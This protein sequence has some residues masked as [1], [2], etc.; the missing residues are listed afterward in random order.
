MSQQQIN[1]RIEKLIRE[2]DLGKEGYNAEEM[3]FIRQYEGWGGQ[4]KKGEGLLYEFYTPD[5]VAGLM[6][7]LAYRYG[8]DGGN[9]LEPAIGTGRLIR[10][11][12]DYSR[13]VGFEIN[14]VSAR[15][16]EICYP[17]VQVHKG[18]F[19]TAFMAAPRYTRRM[20]SGLTWLKEYPFSL[21]I[22]NP[23]YGK[24]TNRY[25]PYFGRPAIPQMEIFFMY[26]GVQLLRSE[27]ILI[28][29]TASGFL[30][31][32]HSYDAIKK[33]LGKFCDLE[34]AYRLPPVFK[35]SKVPVDIIVLR[36][37]NYGNATT[38]ETNSQEKE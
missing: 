23:P 26:Y 15:I 28:Y 11:A 34:D 1:S 31:N 14:P 6:W 24:Y 25:S 33:A 21:V 8:Y 37:N 16:V 38:K 3:D 30:R 10:P 18:Y 12:P 22:G 20:T 19:E 13:C 29:L 35:R 4:A 32:G 17:G 27:G 9:V 5:Y 2:K 36:R 7:D